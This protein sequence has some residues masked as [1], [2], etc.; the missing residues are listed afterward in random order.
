M[1]KL[2]VE[3]TQISEGIIAGFRNAAMSGDEERDAKAQK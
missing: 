2:K 3:K 1:D